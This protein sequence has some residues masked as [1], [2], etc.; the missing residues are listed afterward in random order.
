MADEPKGVVACFINEDGRVISSVSDF[1]LDVYGGYTTKEAQ[2]YRVKRA[3]ASAVANAYC[4]PDYIRS[5]A[6]YLMVEIL[7]DLCRHHKC[8]VHYHF[9]GHA[10]EDA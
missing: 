7:D 8:K 3:L 9:V 4:S 5:L 2:K 6:D 10:D 1:G